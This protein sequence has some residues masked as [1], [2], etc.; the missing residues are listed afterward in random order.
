MQPRP[1]RP[2]ISSFADAGLSPALIAALATGGVTA[3]FPIQSATLPDAL[4][5]QDILGRAQTGSGKTLGFGLPLL[6]RLVATRPGGRVAGRPRGLVLVPTRELAGQVSDVLRP[7][8]RAV[9]LTLTTVVGGVGLPAQV[10]ALARGVDVLV[11]TPG[12]LTDLI[13]R[14]A[15]SLDA[16]EVS[17]LDEADHMCDLGFLPAVRRLI[18]QTPAAGQRMLFSATLDGHVDVLVRE[19]LP[20]PVLVACDPAVS[21]VTAMTHHAF[22]VTDTAGRLA[23]L[24]V[25]GSGHGR[26]LIFAR[27]KHGTDRLARQLAAA[28]LPARALHGGMAQ[29]AR[30]RTL[31]DFV[32]GDPRVLVATDVAARGLHIDDIE[33]VV[34]ADPPADAKTYLHRS[35]RTARAGAGGTVVL[36]SLPEQRRDAA[37]LLG[38]AGLALSPRAVTAGDPRLGDV[39]AETALTAGARGPAP[40]ALGAGRPAPAHPTAGRPAPARPIAGGTAHA[41]AGGAS[42]GLRHPV[43]PGR[44]RP[45]AGSSRR[46]HVRP[47]GPPSPVVPGPVPRA[48]H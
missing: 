39:L 27:T 14:R 24:R 45:G 5:G 37:E 23:V 29:N 8:A 10:A 40:R 36:L 3:P 12:R 6:S 48:Q 1:P 21:V 25:L 17:V 26:T 34:H 44:A 2:P 35:G 13:D 31:A 9:G 4:A 28:G 7:L 42:T 20:D 15:C 46:R 41:P 47:A 38:Q 11:A 32:A 19:F 18:G 30:T 43:A 22:E 16:V 33:L